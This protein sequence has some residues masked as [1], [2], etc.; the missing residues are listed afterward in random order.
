MAA[1]SRAKNVPG[2]R[3][4]R[5]S[6]AVAVPVA[7]R[8]RR[9]W[10]TLSAIVVL[11]AAAGLGVVRSTGRA[12]GAH[13]AAMPADPLPLGPPAAAGALRSPGSA[14]ATGPEGVPVPAVPALA[15]PRT[16]GQPI[17]GIACSVGEQVA[18]HVHAHLTL[19]VNGVSQK[20]PAAVGIADPQA[21][22]TA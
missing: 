8:S 12:G 6:S 3:R 15:A 20:V 18:F 21:Q 17:D 7:K 22:D 13:N 2:R 11:S 19:F 10:W 16:T 14:G 5:G 9:R 4:P 1:R